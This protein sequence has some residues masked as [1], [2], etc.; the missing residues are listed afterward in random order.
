MDRAAGW[1]QSNWRKYSTGRLTGSAIVREL[2][3]VL[4]Q[5]A[6][7]VRGRPAVRF[8]VVPAEELRMAVRCL[9]CGA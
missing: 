4:P 5:A 7:A 8:W 3:G 9:R 6:V 1:W 2:D